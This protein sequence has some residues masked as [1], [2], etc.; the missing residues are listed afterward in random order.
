MHQQPGDTIT[1]ASADGQTIKT[2]TVVGTYAFR[3]SRIGSHIGNI[4]AS[5]KVVRAL[6]P[7]TTGV[8]TLTYMKVKLRASRQCA[9]QAW[10]DRSKRSGT[11]PGRYRRIR[12]TAP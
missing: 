3:G 4:L 9:D 1:L 10:T 11:Q 6:S 8:T 7:A 5:T 12:W 2:L